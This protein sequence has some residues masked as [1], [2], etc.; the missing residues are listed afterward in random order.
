M[1]TETQS[2]EAQAEETA[3]AKFHAAASLL[4]MQAAIRK[5]TKG[6]TSVPALMTG[7]ER[8][9][10]RRI[11]ERRSARLAGLPGGFAHPSL[12]ARATGPGGAR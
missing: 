1:Q 10:A 7:R 4:V 6:R 3:S 12:S 5:A 8:R 9:R 11:L 2:P